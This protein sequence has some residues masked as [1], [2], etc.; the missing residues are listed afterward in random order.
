MPHFVVHALDA[1]GKGAARVTNR[2]AHRARLRQHD[3]P[4]TVQ[5]GGP[6][7]DDSGHMCGTMLV[8]QAAK[9]ADVEAYL[10][11]DPYTLAGVYEQ[12]SIRAFKWGLGNPE[13]RH[14]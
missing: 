12:I 11:N 8:I 9:R 2:S 1:P 4:L 13:E 14:G 5:V 6:L 7:L 3:H 10:A